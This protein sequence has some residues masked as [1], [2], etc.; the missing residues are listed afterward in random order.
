MSLWALLAA[1]LLAGNDLTRMTDETKAILTNREVI[2]IDQDP[3]GR[4]G[5]RVRAEGPLEVWA[6][7]LAG[8]GK[9]VGLFN[10]SDQPANMDVTFA[11][12]GFKGPVKARDVWGAKDLGRVKSYHAVV[13]GHGTVLLRLGG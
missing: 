8:G 6:R 7:P 3:A 2:A 13:V 5:D 12:L 11:E 4:Q 9:A 10:L 1:P